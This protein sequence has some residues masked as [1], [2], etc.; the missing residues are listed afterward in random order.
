[1]IN[2]REFIKQSSK[3]ALALSVLSASKQFL[4]SRS[5]RSRSRA[6]GKWRTGRF[7]KSSFKGIRR[8]EP[9]HIKG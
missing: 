3:A 4:Y 2:R 1:M 8:N 5:N 9:F 7:I 6:G